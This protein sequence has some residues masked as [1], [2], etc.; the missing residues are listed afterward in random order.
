M[1]GR[2]LFVIFLSYLLFSGSFHVYAQK[3]DS[4]IKKHPVL[5]LP[6]VARSIETGWS[7][8]AAAALTFHLRSP[9]DTLTRTSNLQALGLYTVQKQMVLAVNG[10]IYFPGE[11][12]IL[13]QQLSYSY[14][15]DKFWGLGKNT[16][17][18]NK[19]PYK[20]RQFYI[21]LHP[22]RKLGQNIFLGV[23]YE[24]QR[25]WSVQYEPGGLFDREDIQGRKGYHVSGAGV[26][27]TYDS[28]NN[29]FAPD[30]GSMFQFY[31]NRFDHLFGSNY[32]YTNFVIDLRKFI[33]I[34]KRQVLAMQVYGFFN[35]GD[36]PLRSLASFGGANSMRGYYDGRYRD[37]NL[38]VF[39]TEYRF[40]LFW[41]LGAVVFGGI[42]NVSS[43]FEDSDFNY[44]K[45]SYGGGLRIALN[46]AERLNLRL[47]Y[48][49][50]RGSNN[51]FYFQLGEAF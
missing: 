3:A 32:Q 43:H 2:R 35:T 51:G 14:F 45:Y 25:V 33:S 48:G 36:V 19:E 21:Y 46:K 34:Y 41:R 40:P 22:Q 7:F 17:E 10:T 15:P 6:V 42:G 16:P 38:A 39:Q 26:S 1:P 30:R 50:G 24:Y 5:V 28:R 12:F 8:G 11:K 37:K 49:I 20:Y 31:F 29:A 13:T 47:D 23:R 4:A 44:L 18:S 27:F 9:G